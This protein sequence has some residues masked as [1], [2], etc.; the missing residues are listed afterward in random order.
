M[1]STE[2]DPFTIVEQLTTQQTDQLYELLRQQFWG[3]KR[4]REDL[5]VMM[6]NTSLSLGL[7]ERATDRLVGYCRV[8]TDFVFRATVYDVM[9]TESLQGQGLGK[10]LVDALMNHPR[11]QRVSVIYLCCEPE[12]YSFYQQWGFAPYAGRTEWMVKIQR[13]E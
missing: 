1:N 9:L 12:M 6:D 13:E 8:L 4:S 11:L 10:R 5:D 7:V 3:G 2:S